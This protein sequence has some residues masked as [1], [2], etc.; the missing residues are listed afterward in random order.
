MSRT[1]NLINLLDACEKAEF[2]EVVKA[3]L[4]EEF[5][6]KKIVFTD[7][8]NDGGIDIKV[9]DFNGQGIQYQ[10][11]TQKS[12]TPQEQKAFEKKVFE[13]VEKAKK[14]TESHKFSNKLIF[15]YSKELTQIKIRELEKTAFKSYSIDLEIIEANRL[16][17][18]S[19]NI[20]EIQ[21][22]LYKL[23]QL[24]EYK[25]KSSTFDNEQENFVFDLISFGKASEFKVQI[26]EAF[27][28]QTFYSNSKITLEEIKKLCEEKF[29]VKEGNTFYEKLIN[30]LRTEQR[31]IKND[32]KSFSLTDE[33][34]KKVKIKSEQHSIDEKL[35]IQNIGNILK[36]YGQEQYIDDY[37]LELKKL[38]AN[39]FNSDLESV[40]QDSNSGKLIGISKDFFLFAESKL[41]DKKDGTPLAKKLLRFCLE[42]K[43]IQKIAASKI[44]C[45]NIN[46]SKLESYLTTQKKFF[47]DTQIAIY[48]LC[49]YYNHK[50][51]FNNYFFK[52]TRELLNFAKREGFNFHISERYIWEVQSHIRDAMNISP[53]TKIEN[54]SKLG[55]SK[56]VFYNF[57][58]FLLDKGEIESNINF[59]KFLIDF[60]FGDFTSGK[61][62]NAK[63][64]SYLYNLDIHK[65]VNNKDYDISDTK[66]IFK[67]LL[68][69]NNKFKISF[70]LENDCIMTEFLA[71]TDVDVHPLQPVFIT[72]DKIFFD[73]Q[74]DYHKEFPNAQK[75]ITV[76]PSKLIDVYSI[77]KFS[78]NTETVTESLLAHISDE[79]ISNTHAL[80]D[81]ITFILNPN[82]EV[83]LQYANR[84]A[85][86]REDEINQ[87]N[88]SVIIPP[89]N[90]EGVAVIDDVFYQ[91]TSHYQKDDNYKI[92][93]LKQ[94][95]LK[96]ELVDTIIT[97]L[98]KAVEDFYKTRQIGDTMY[99]TFD[100]LILDVEKTSAN[101]TEPKSE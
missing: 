73:V 18:E 11:T 72:W 75:W 82:D 33:E 97:V 57:Y 22:L 47:L 16:A 92:D 65:E 74:T 30:K 48:A 15:F 64:E 70:T 19:E 5:N 43:F 55:P 90:F 17:E 66:R 88:K 4:K 40:I 56:N 29:K 80:I 32:D 62:I 79:L 53:F 45:D 39:N 60:G 83:G 98:L 87:I 81:T 78:I 21:R 7:G 100:K 91:L 49:Y 68:A 27:I 13:D 46:N 34:T 94:V 2:D 14:N 67:R 1:K 6:F 10:L 84:L 99:Q 26:I 77:L 51:K 89:D 23:N 95:F 58:K 31:I 50:S 24:D 71:D 20:I 59:D 86:I 54:F 35:F 44:Y 12:K 37:I 93:T 63:I 41:K 96:K 38:Y 25:V 8:K 28:L 9:F 36:E 101:K 52:T 61:S 3:Y 69:K 76:Q 42:N 85:K